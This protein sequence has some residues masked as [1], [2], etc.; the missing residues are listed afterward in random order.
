MEELIK[1]CFEYANPK[2]IAEPVGKDA[3]KAPPKKGEEV[4]V[5]PYQGMDTTVYKEI[6]K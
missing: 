5:D 3:K 4:P 6:G 1:E 2:P